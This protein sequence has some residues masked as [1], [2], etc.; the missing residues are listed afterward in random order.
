M[1]RLDLASCCD[2]E[3]KVSGWRV[4]VREFE[5]G[6]DVVGSVRARSSDR[7]DAEVVT[8]SPDG[9]QGK[10]ATC[11]VSY[12]P[13]LCHTGRTVFVLLRWMLL[14]L[15]YSRILFPARGRGQD[16]GVATC[17]TCYLL[18]DLGRP[19]CVNHRSLGSL[20]HGGDLETLAFDHLLGVEMY[21]SKEMQGE[22]PL[23][24]CP[25]WNVKGSASGMGVDPGRGPCLCSRGLCCLACH[26]GG[27]SDGRAKNE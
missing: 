1:A 4:R 17:P 24:N 11:H 13:F 22:S 23:C 26:R 25:S 16:S 27:G 2:T 7:R 5:V 6:D 3:V 8:A 12:H 21:L 9:S 14:A 19:S 18:C 10:G 20:V 15:F